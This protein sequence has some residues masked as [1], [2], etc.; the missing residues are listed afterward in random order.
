MKEI[1]IVKNNF[2]VIYGVF[3]NRNN[4]VAKLWQLYDKMPSEILDFSMCKTVAEY[5]SEY[6]RKPADEVYWCDAEMTRFAYNDE[7]TGDHYC[8][9]IESS[10]VE[11]MPDEK[12]EDVPVDRLMLAFET[13]ER[14]KRILD[15]RE[16]MDRAEYGN[17]EEE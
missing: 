12:R 17:N 6:G 2:G 5:E 8:Y 3:A 1:F 14:I 9:E 13:V 16:M 4:A 10:V 15:T 7:V 11:D